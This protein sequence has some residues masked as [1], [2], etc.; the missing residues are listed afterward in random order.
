M[1]EAKITA[2]KGEKEENGKSSDCVRIVS[3][4]ET[5]IKVLMRLT[6]YE[7][8]PN[9]PIRPS[10]SD[11]VYIVADTSGAGFGSCYGV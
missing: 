3:H 10:N 8:P 4:L 9:V 2:R 6:C 1:P 11:A 5:D 7:K